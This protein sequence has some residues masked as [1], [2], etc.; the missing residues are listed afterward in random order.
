MPVRKT[1]T[2]EATHAVLKNV[3][4]ESRVVSWLLHDGWQIFTPVID[5]GHQTDIL[6][7]DGPHYHRIQVKTVDA[8][9]GKN[10][11]IANKW[12][13]SCVDIVVVFARNSCW[14]YVFPAF[15]QGHCLVNAAGHQ[16]FIQ[17]R[18]AFLKAFHKI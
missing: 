4:F 2:K 8:D 3:S 12:K 11:Y 6:I 5:N 17:N 15:T 7:S 9:K 14:G 13:N 18:A 16:P 10:Q 1:K